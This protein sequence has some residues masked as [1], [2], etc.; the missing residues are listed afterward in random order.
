[1]RNT[2]FVTAAVIAAVGCGSPSEPAPREVEAKPAPAAAP[3]EAA[4]RK[5]GL[6][7]IGLRDQGMRS[8]QQSE[9][10]PPPGSK[11]HARQSTDGPTSKVRVKMGEATL[12][13]GLE[14]ELVARVVRSHLAEVRTCYV[15]GLENNPKLE[16]EVTI[17]FTI[18]PSGD[19]L[20][21][22]AK[23]TPKK[24]GDL[25]DCLVEAAKAWRFP[26]PRNGTKVVVTYP[27]TLSQAE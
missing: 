19:V 5:T 13:G 20:V 4:P 23:K 7:E 14:Q 27:F 2:R 6:E 18:G 8:H 11:D 15:K 3:K 9:Y 25:K 1:V 16:G 17:A 22:A 24:S 10:S 12:R 21:A 26:Q